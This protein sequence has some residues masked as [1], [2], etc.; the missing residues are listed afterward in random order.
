MGK[1]LGFGMRE[2]KDSIAGSGT[3]ARSSSR[4]AAFREDDD[5]VFA[6]PAAPTAPGRSPTAIASSRLEPA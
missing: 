2:F 5:L 4:A 6:H 3:T 1:S